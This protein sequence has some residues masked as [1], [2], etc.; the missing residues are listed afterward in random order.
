MTNVEKVLDLIFSNCFIGNEITVEMI[1]GFNFKG[2]CS[3]PNLEGSKYDLTAKQVMVVV[4]SLLKK[5]ILKTQQKGI[6]G[7]QAI[8]KI[9]YNPAVPPAF[10]ESSASVSS[11]NEEK[12]NP[13]VEYTEEQVGKMFITA[14]KN[15]ENNNRR[16]E[17]KIKDLRQKFQMIIKDLQ[18][19]LDAERKK[20]KEYQDICK[21]RDNYNK[22]SQTLKLQDV[23]RVVKGQKNKDMKEDTYKT[24]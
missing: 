5:G 19:N 2:A 10:S 1:M 21:M 17:N 24:V 8:Y 11:E 7:K 12:L 14:F 4:N 23:V 20:R 22:S 13:I 6:G 9:M 3:E 15:L 16:L 18:D